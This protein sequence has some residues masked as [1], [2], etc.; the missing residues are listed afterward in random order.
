MPQQPKPKYCTFWIPSVAHNDFQIIEEIIYS[1]PIPGSN[2]SSYQLKSDISTIE[3]NK[4]SIILT[5][6]EITS[7]GK[8][9]NYEVNLLSVDYCISGLLEFKYALTSH[10]HC[11][12]KR[13]LSHAYRL[14][15][16][17]FHRHIY[18]HPDKEGIRQPFVSNKFCPLNEDD[19]EVLVFYLKQ[20]HELISQQVEMIHDIVP[21]GIEDETGVSKEELDKRR[22]DMELFYVKC[23]NLRGQM[24]F[25]H[26]L[27]N[28]PFNK[29]CHVI[30]PPPT[31]QLQKELHTIAHN[32]VNLSNSIQNLFE[33]SKTAFYIKNINTSFDIQSSIKDIAGENKRLI[34]EVQESNSVSSKLGKLSLRIS[35]IMGVL[36]LILGAISVWLG[37]KSLNTI[38]SQQTPTTK[39]NNTAD[40]IK[41]VP[42]LNTPSHQIGSKTIP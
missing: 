5:V 25:F 29:S 7:N 12:F 1:D 42:I 34:E 21:S 9:S 8:K 4:F 31:N 2:G 27:L 11:K 26:S 24:P 32:I 40:S 20:V 10:Y 19:N 35:I 41:K 28:S 3:S 33:K 14:V 6:T 36:S 30:A 23:E 37:V 13:I 17:H 38:P 16:K 22:K 39:V 15:V 18:H